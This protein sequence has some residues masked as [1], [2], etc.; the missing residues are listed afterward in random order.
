MVGFDILKTNKTGISHF[1]GAHHTLPT[2]DGRHQ[3]RKKT[4]GLFLLVQET[5]N[6]FWVFTITSII[7][8][9]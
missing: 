3:F 1:T 9:C 8:F 2:Q 5:G 7:I 4:D 6:T